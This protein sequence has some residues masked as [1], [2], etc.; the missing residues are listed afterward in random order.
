MR[1][2]SAAGLVRPPVD[3]ARVPQDRT[4]SL[5]VEQRALGQWEPLPSKK[6]GGPGPRAATDKRLQSRFLV[7]VDAHLLK[8]GIVQ[9]RGPV[10]CRKT[11]L[12]QAHWSLVSTL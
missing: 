4:G 8:A 10:A 7:N 9:S 3:A 6:L 1:L 5:S 11:G 12:G 2:S